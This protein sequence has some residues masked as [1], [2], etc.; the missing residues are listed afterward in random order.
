MKGN[1][2]K[3]KLRPRQRRLAELFLQAE[4]RKDTATLVSIY[5]KAGFKGVEKSATAVCQ[6]VLELPQ[7][8]EYIQKRIKEN[9]AEL[10]ETDA[11]LQAVMLKYATWMNYDVRKLY[12]PNGNLKEPQELDDKTAASVLSVDVETC[13]DSKRD[14]ET[15]R[16]KVKVIDPKG[17]ADSLARVLT[18][19]FG[20]ELTLK[21]EITHNVKGGIMLV[22]SPMTMD[23]WVKAVPA[24]QEFK[25]KQ[26]RLIGF[27]DVVKV[28]VEKK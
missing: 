27:D 25:A 17:A 6:S 24:L 3:G 10:K 11:S 14:T 28:K 1:I 5:K 22:P 12:D 23:E 8:Q 18:G 21:G 4:C 13:I 7:V 26:K 2:G 16:S 20:N 19:G 9:V 15:T